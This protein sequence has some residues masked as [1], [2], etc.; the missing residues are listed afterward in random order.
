M[1]ASGA[2]LTLSDDVLA[3][4]GIA[5]T[6]SVIAKIA[7]SVKDEKGAV[8]AKA[9][10]DKENKIIEPKW[11]DLFTSDGQADIY[12]FQMAL[13]TALAAFFVTVKI[14]ET[15]KF[16][17]LPAGWLTL[18]GISNGVYLL[19][20]GTSKT[21][22]E[23]LGEK[24]DQVQKAEEELAKLS[25]EADDAGKSLQDLEAQK[26][27]AKAKRLKA[28]QNLE[29]AAVEQKA[30]LEKQLGQMKEESQAAGDS[31]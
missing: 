14:F 21:K 29:M 1:V 7:A 30:T 5:G 8:I 18:I 2:L 19:A 31:L 28:D 6:A 13:F 3:L 26:N 11:L 24:A 17:E 25:K 9:E 27:A 22:S 15:L 20:K 16:P 23:Q 10:L 4:L 12:K